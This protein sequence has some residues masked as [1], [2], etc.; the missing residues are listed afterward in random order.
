M[1][2]AT[3]FSTWSRIT[4]SGPSATAESLSTPRCGRQAEQ[5]EVLLVGREAEAAAALLLDAQNHDD[6]GPFDGLLDARHD[7]RARALDLAGQERRRA[8]ERDT[9]A[10]L[11]QKR[12]VRARDTAVRDVAA[13]RN[14]QARERAFRAADREGVE[15]GLRGMRVRA[16]ARVHD[17]A[18]EVPRQ[19]VRGSR[20]LVADDDRVRRHRHEVPPRVEERLALRDRRACGGE[21]DRVGGKTALGDLERKARARGVLEKEVRDELAAEGRDFLDG[22]L[23][24][25]AHRLGRVED[26]PDVVLG[27][28]LDV[29]EVLPGERRRARDGGLRGFASLRGHA[30]STAYFFERRFGRFRAAGRRAL[31]AA[32][33][34]ASRSSSQTSSTPS[35]SRNVTETISVADVATLLPTNCAS[36]GSS[37]RPRS[38][39]T[40]RR[41][42]RGR[43]KSR[44]ASIAAR[45]VRPV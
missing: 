2:T 11:R 35:V 13:D 23:V 24:D 12:H 30:V 8:E 38:T 45:T 31:R 17:R 19:E 10:H 6:V 29:E 41:I 32:F 36:I 9:R 16:V 4:E 20:A 34:E 14:S 15:Q 37:R 44:M 27:D 5:L 7:A 21:R 40:A 43:P 42:F 25:L 18:R 3:P 39:R 33:A 1:R 22:A 28:R 26:E